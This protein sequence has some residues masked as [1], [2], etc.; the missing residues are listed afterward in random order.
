M[1]GAAF[2]SPQNLEIFVLMDTSQWLW[3]TIYL[4][5]RT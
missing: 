5:S 2:V 4:V 1:I 3:T